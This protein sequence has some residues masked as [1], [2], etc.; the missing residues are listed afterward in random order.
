MKLLYNSS[1]SLPSFVSVSGMSIIIAPT[2]SGSFSTFQVYLEN[3]G[4]SADVSSS[5]VTFSVTVNQQVSVCGN[6]ILEAGESC[7][8]GNTISGDGCD[9][10]CNVEENYYCTQ[11]STSVCKKY[12]EA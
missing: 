4:N 7:D 3:S 10:G 11:T 8:D 1:P 9:M 12:P 6:G 2:S 5:F